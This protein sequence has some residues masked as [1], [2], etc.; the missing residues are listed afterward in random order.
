MTV[1]CSRDLTNFS[2]EVRL[3]IILIGGMFMTILKPL[4]LMVTLSLPQFKPPKKDKG[5]RVREEPIH[6][7]TNPIMN[8]NV[9]T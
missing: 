6:H 8:V 7:Q 9:I 5:K 4:K 2:L 3:Q 1:I